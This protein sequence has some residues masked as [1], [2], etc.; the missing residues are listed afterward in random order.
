MKNIK[1]ELKIDK[2]ESLEFYSKLLDK[3]INMILDEALEEY[4]KVQDEKIIAK[5]QNATN[6]S[7]DEFWEGVDI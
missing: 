2:I 7:Y 6:L 3:D 5:E 4:F 1:L